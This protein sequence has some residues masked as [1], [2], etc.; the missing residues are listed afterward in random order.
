MYYYRL[1]IKSLLLTP[2]GIHK[3]IVYTNLKYY[4]KFYFTIRK[5]GETILAHIG[6]LKKR[7]NRK[8]IR[9]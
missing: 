4:E 7:T 9:I 6:T 1:E 3:V 8:G 2:T 5:D